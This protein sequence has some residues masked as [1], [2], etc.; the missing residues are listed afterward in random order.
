[1]INED[2]LKPFVQDEIYSSTNSE[3]IMHTDPHKAAMLKALVKR[4]GVVSYAAKDAGLSR[5]AHYN[6]L[7]EDEKYKS[8]YELISEVVI[9]FTETRLIEYINMSD[10]RAIT[11]MLRT[12]GKKRGYTYYKDNNAQK[13]AIY[14]IIVESEEMKALVEMNRDNP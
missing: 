2:S 14:K 12:R 6:W 5:Q 7:N 3:D 9:D 13:D 11:F 1:M 4:L 10:L 8:A